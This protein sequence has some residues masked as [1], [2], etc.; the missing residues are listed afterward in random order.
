MFCLGQQLVYMPSEG[1]SCNRW[2]KCEMRGASGIMASLGVVFFVGK[3]P[4][5]MTTQRDG[6]PAAPP[7]FHKTMLGASTCAWFLLHRTHFAVQNPCR[8]FESRR[9]AK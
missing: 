6:A 7:L 8:G 1:P 9:A 3:E 4:A 5:L 2:R